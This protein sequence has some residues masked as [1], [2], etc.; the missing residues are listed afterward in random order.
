MKENC[1][2]YDGVKVNDSKEEVPDEIEVVARKNA[3]LRTEDTNVTC[4]LKPG[5]TVKCEAH[6]KEKK[7]VKD[8]LKRRQRNAKRIAKKLR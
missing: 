1:D 8:N 3:A 4:I 6:W 2:N 7:L 5:K